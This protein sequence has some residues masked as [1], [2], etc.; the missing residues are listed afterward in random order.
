MKQPC[1]CHPDDNPPRPCPQ[2]YAYSECVAAAILERIKAEEAALI[3]LPS[4]SPS[5]DQGFRCAL[6]TIEAAILAI[7]TVRRRDEGRDRGMGEWQPIETAPHET[8]VLLFCPD[9][10]IANPERIELGVASHGWT[11]NGV[12]NRSAHAW[13][14]HWM[15]LP[16]APQPSERSGDGARGMDA[17]NDVEGERG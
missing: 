17:T 11:R 13:A 16:P 1:T 10:G 14:T 15:P 9:K 5:Y 6:Q 8:D 4:D 7:P 3:T 12:S 2:R